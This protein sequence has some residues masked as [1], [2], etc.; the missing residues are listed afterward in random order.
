MNSNVLSVREML[1]WLPHLQDTYKDSPDWFFEY[2]FTKEML[3]DIFAY[4]NLTIEQ[5]L[6]IWRNGPDLSNDDFCIKAFRIDIKGKEMLC[7][8]VYYPGAKKF[9]LMHE[10]TLLDYYTDRDIKYYMEKFYE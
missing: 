4:H 7:Y 5:L 9:R 3:R 2:K 10:T 8:C 1:E 6:E